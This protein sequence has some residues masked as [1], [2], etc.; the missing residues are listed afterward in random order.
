[1]LTPPD[2]WPTDEI[3]LTARVSTDTVKYEICNASATNQNF[4]TSPP[5]RFLVI[6]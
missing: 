1:V 2:G 4:G 6:R 3:N 5:V